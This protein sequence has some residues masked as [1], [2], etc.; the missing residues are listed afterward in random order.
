MT[1]TI[2]LLILHGLVAVALLGGIT[3]QSV[4]AIRAAL[5]PRPAA[6]SAG[7]VA[8]YVRVDDRVFTYATVVLY[9]VTA[10]L[11]AVIYPSYRID[12][13]IPFEELGLSWAVGLFEVKEHWAAVG[14]GILPLYVMAW[15][16][17]EMVAGQG[18]RLIS[19]LMIAA[20][21]WNNFLVGHVLNNIR[22]LG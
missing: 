15:R 16:S 13:R 3:H 4:S 8:S 12:V 9:I 20:I 5:K 14:L 10:V 17:R 1:V 19:T 18:L 2:A 11:G 6:G 21:V 7:F 22:G